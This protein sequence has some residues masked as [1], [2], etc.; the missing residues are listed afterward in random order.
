MAIN[1]KKNSRKKSIM[2]ISNTFFASEIKYTIVER[3]LLISWQ[4][5]IKSGNPDVKKA[6]T[7]LRF[8]LM[9][10]KKY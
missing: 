1:L 9:K 6:R 4:K 8:W 5:Y 7:F 10:L 3:F 2:K